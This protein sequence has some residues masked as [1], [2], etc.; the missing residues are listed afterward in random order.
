NKINPLMLIHRLPFQK[1][2]YEK[3][4]INIYD[5]IN[6][7]FND[8]RNGISSIRAGG[9]ML[10][11]CLFIGTAIFFLIQS[12]VHINLNSIFIILISHPI[13]VYPT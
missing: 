2:R 12:L 13:V 3:M 4:G 1:R 7:A 6:T 10:V 11:L 8:T 9:V 5:E